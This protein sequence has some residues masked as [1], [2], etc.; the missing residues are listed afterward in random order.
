MMKLLCTRSAVIFA[1]STLTL[2][3]AARPTS[4][5]SGL[6][7]T[8]SL[9]SVPAFVAPHDPAMGAV[10][11]IVPSVEV[12]APEAAIL[13]DLGQAVRA[14][15]ITSLASSPNLRVAD[16]ELLAEIASEQKLNVSNATLPDGRPSLGHLLPAR[17]AIKVT[18]N[19][20]QENVRGKSG[21]NRV[22]LGPLLGIIGAV[23]SDDTTSA[24]LKGGAAANPTV[25]VGSEI[26]EGVV[27]LEVRVTDLESGTVVGV[28]RALGKLSRKN[29]KMVLGIAGISSSSSE[30]Q[31]SVLAH[32]T[33]VAAEEATRQIHEMLRTRGRTYATT[34]L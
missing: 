30:F 3:C 11:V 16:R 24:V 1:G 18:V 15:L 6:A 29:S 22:E 2:G 34:K 8:S 31:H 17:Y 20:F 27:G 4:S 10:T 14:Q 13:G 23:V 9:I 19:E 21:G 12:A 5:D 25:G 26:V 32:A 7:A 33:R 28:T